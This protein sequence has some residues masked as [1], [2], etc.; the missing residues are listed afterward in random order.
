MLH[1]P[2]VALVIGLAV[3]SWAAVGDLP[4]RPLVAFTGQGLQGTS[5]LDA[6]MARVLARRD[7]NWK[8]MQQYILDEHE[9]FQLTGPDGSRLYGFARDYT[10]FIR[11]G[12][13]I[14]S[15]VRVDGVRIGEDE[16]RAA[17]ARWLARER[18]REKRARERAERRGDNPEEPG[19]RGAAPGDVGSDH[20][21]TVQDV[22]G[23]SLEPRFVSAAY[24]LRFKFDPGH[25]A[26]AGRERLGDRDV[27]RIEYYPSRLFTE[28]RT[29]PNRR[30]RER[31]EEIEEKMNK[32]SLVTLWIDPA[33]HQIVQYTFDNMDMDF[34]P[35]RSVVRVDEL[36]ASMRMS[37][38]FPDIWLP[39]AIEMRFRLLLAL[40]PVAARY[41]VAY[42]DYRLAE[43]TARVKPGE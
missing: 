40:G 22:I 28:G 6:F 25:Y 10:W 26:L 12:Y 20:P 37:Q 34:L 35:G 5:D 14:R 21:D 11:E 19:A 39:A 27:L 1:R 18:A 2:L 13:F 3:A 33:R 24:F 29:R 17:E 30:V 16:R 4:P 15:P 23:G 8:K 7:E 36:K 9:R 31:D 41:D 32:V 43:V 38:P 42:V